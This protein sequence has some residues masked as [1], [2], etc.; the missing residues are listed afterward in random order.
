MAGLPYGDPMGMVIHQSLKQ[1]RCDLLIF[2]PFRITSK[3]LKNKSP[4]F[5]EGFDV[6]MAGFE[7]YIK[8]LIISKLYFVYVR[9]YPILV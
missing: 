2:H 8:I 1:L 6:G 5:R 4:H 3:V 9:T 7:L